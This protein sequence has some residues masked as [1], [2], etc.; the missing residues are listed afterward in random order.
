M[1]SRQGYPHSPGYNKSKACF[2]S[3]STNQHKEDTTP[4]HRGHGRNADR[5][6][7]P[8]PSGEKG[9]SGAAPN[10][11]KDP[12]T[13]TPSA[14]SPGV[15]S[16]TTSKM[17]LAQAS[18]AKQATTVTVEAEGLTLPLQTTV[19]AGARM[20]SP[21]RSKTGEL[22]A[23]A[24]GSPRNLHKTTS[25]TQISGSA[26][27]PKSLQKTVSAAAVTSPDLPKNVQRASLSQI[28]RATSSPK[29][30]PTSAQATLLTVDQTD[31][32]KKGARR[33]GVLSPSPKLRPTADRTQVVANNLQGESTVQPATALSKETSPQRH[34]TEEEGSSK[35][36]GG[37]SIL[38]DIQ[39]R[40]IPKGSDSS[41][42]VVSKCPVSPQDRRQPS[43]AAVTPSAAQSKETAA[44][45]DPNVMTHEREC[46]TEKRKREER[47]R[48]ER[49]K[50]R[51]REKM[52]E[53]REE[54]RRREER[55]KEG[56][57]KEKE[58]SQGKVSGMEQEV[59]GEQKAAGQVRS[60]K[61]ASTMTVE[62]HPPGR[63]LNAGMQT[64]LGYMDAEVQAVVEVTSRSTA[65]S[66]TLDL[67]PLSQKDSDLSNLG[68]PSGTPCMSS[69]NGLSP[70][71][72]SDSDWPSGLSSLAAGAKPTFLGPP[73]YKSPN[74]YRA[75]RQHVCQIEIEMCSQSSLSDSLALPRVTVSEA[76]P[77]SPGGLE[78]DSDQSESKI[79]ATGTNNFEK[80]PPPEVVWDEQGMTWEVYGAAVDMESLGFAIQNH[81]Q[82]KIREHEQRI[83]TLRKSISLSERSPPDGKGMK[84]Q[85]KRNVFR[86]LFGGPACCAKAPAKAEAAQ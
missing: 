5:G 36:T 24:R 12:T 15:T 55:E 38:Q 71:S 73:P 62:D 22:K 23:T 19:M 16:P 7:G 63:T 26:N 25:A 60:F 13:P 75:P 52:K 47:E 70:D 39:V 35:T 53:R 18:A 10:Q 32:C 67:Q 42:Q 51:L 2:E 1:E 37:Q 81:L 44:K 59:E 41:L 20:K 84:K 30:R 43:P 77:V 82:K 86:S 17:L 85:K 34:N 79:E 45:A 46:V 64:D 76:S 72:S 40:Q 65:T 68:K 78:K 66:P 11:P 58:G 80:G 56:E 3:K 83:G 28:P 9:T 50:E 69:L 74:S 48:E 29:L 8:V 21:S 4:L 54:E 14:S 49:E 61:D 33:E 6:N 57:R 27:S 31:A